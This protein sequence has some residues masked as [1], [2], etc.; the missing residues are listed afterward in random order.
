MK[1]ILTLIFAI[2]AFSTLQAQTTKEEARRVI[3]GG[4]NDKTNTGNNERTRNERPR[5]VIYDGNTS[6]DSRQA[7]INRINQEYDNKISSIRNNST[8]SQEEKQRMIAQLE[9]DRAAKIRQVNGRNNGDYDKK[10]NKKKNKSKAKGQ[11]GK[12]LGW[13]KGVGNPHRTG[14]KVKAKKNKN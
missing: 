1:K 4:S 6:N 2:A 13:E 12:K 5:D 11:N 10:K 9:K 8:L 7:E 14:G 3:L